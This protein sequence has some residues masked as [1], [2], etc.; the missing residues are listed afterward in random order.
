MPA[1]GSRATGLRLAAGEEGKA[2]D[3]S[4]WR[5]GVI[6]GRV[7]DGDGEPVESVNIWAIPA[8]RGRAMNMRQA[9]TDDRGEFRIGRLSAG[10]YKL[11][12]MRQH[13][14][15][16]LP[17][18]AP[19]EPVMLYAPTFYPSALDATAGTDVTVG[20]G[21]ERSGMEIRLLKT[22]A[23]RVSGR[24]SG[25]LPPDAQV[26]LTLQPYET[27]EV[28]NRMGMVNAMRSRNTAAGADGR[29]MFSNVTAGEYIL[30]AGIHR[31]GSALSGTV[32]IRVGQQE[33][34]NVALSLQPLARVT[35]RVL[36]DGGGKLPA[37]PMSV[38][39]RGAEP[40][41]PAGGGAQVKPDG[42]FVMENLQRTRMLVTQQAPRGWYL[43]SVSVGGQPQVGLEF[44]LSG[45]DAAVE[46]TYSNRPGTVTGTVEGATEGVRVAAVPENGSGVPSFANL[47]RTGAVT[48]G[49]NSFKIEDVAPG[50]YVLI[51]CIPGHLEAIS[52]PATWEKVKGKAVSVKVDEGGTVTGSPRLI[53]E[54]DLDE[55]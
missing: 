19:G 1:P 36:A 10:P 29:F 12:A 13:N 25:E 4:I 30:S 9:I 23:V 7:T 6:S 47:Y 22:I 48:P 32:R 18:V 16:A 49:Q 55:K 27:G 34:D 52:D 26:S 45:G 42:T 39:V 54:S 33:V 14:G 46:F 31:P 43:K 17:N 15:A 5:Q 11:L 3:I 40:W 35:G 53:S 24:V 44:D 50:N 37:G 51:A 38:S 2:G 8:G 21:E 41:L 20:S 28:R